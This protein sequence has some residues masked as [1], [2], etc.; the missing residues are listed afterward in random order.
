[1]SHTKSKSGPPRFQVG[2]KVGVQRDQPR[3]NA[4]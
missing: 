3:V 2:N 4:P 1:M